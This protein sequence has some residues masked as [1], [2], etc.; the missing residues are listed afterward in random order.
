MFRLTKKNSEGPVKLT[1]IQRII[2]GISI[3]IFHHYVNFFYENN[4]NELKLKGFLGG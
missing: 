2:L 3:Q 1:K 4:S